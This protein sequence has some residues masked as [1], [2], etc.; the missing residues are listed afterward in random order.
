MAGYAIMR[1]AKGSGGAG[2][3]EAHHER[4]KDEYKSNP[5]IRTQYSDRNIHLVEPQERYSRE[6]KAR[7]E[8]AKERNPKLQIRKNSVRYVDTLITA[9]PSYFQGLPG[10]EVRRYFETALTF[11]KER[12]NEHNIVSAV[13]HVDERTPHMHLV[14]VPITD[15]DRLSAKDILG[16]PAGCRKWQ[17]DFFRK[18][19][20]E[21][22]GLLRGKDAELTGRK[23]LTPQK[24][25][26]V[27]GKESIRERLNT[28][29]EL[30]TL[31][32][33]VKSIP[34]DLR[35]EIKE[36]NKQTRAL[37]KSMTRERTR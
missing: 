14:F 17:D 33:Y 28:M 7:I 5:D 21:F 29:Q 13:I 32:R 30:E 27:A 12:V 10:R 31:R 25:K 36:R 19:S 3:I 9:S 20:S 35:E 15:D 18:M 1:F 6:I 34:P 37:K 23:H 2:G 11:F 8:A 4:M 26:A 16:G 24:Y 22:P